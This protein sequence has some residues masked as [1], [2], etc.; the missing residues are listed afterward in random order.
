[1]GMLAPALPARADIIFTPLNIPISPCNVVVSGSCPG[2]DFLT[3][4]GKAQFE[5]SDTYRIFVTFPPAPA[6]TSGHLGV[7]GLQ[8][9]A[10]VVV[11]PTRFGF[12]AAA[13]P[14]GAR[15]G[16]GAS[17]R[18]S[19][20]MASTLGY[21]Y[22]HPGVRSGPWANVSD[23]FLGLR[24]NIDGQPHFGWAELRVG[25]GHGM[26]GATLEGVAYNTVADQPIQTLPEPTTLGLLAL[27]SAGLALW[28]R[29]TRES[30]V[31]NRESKLELS[32]DK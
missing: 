30:G 22:G 32:A 18:P 5:L 14:G 26:V 4:K 15:I 6:V 24:F 8:P 1:M 25:V 12:G 13:L 16:P 9:G 17:F 28:R 29:R 2:V 3:V 19:A 11:V 23:A 20:V 21:Y 7:G 31:A 27:G 10:S